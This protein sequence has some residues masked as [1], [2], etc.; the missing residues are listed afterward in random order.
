MK[1]VIWWLGL[2]VL[3][4][5]LPMAL[6]APSSG[7]PNITCE[8]R[9]HYRERLEGIA[10]G[11]KQFSAPATKK[12]SLPA[13]HVTSDH[14][15][16]TRI[17]EGKVAHLPYRFTIKWSETQGKIATLEVNVTGAAGEP[18]AGFPQSSRDPFADAEA[19]TTKAFEIPLTKAM[20][21]QIEER[22][23]AKNQRLTH[24]DLVIVSGG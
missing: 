8:V 17:V 1:N 15:Q 6:A 9:Y 2:L 22:L 11:G 3:G 13:S 16:K 24:V 7:A 18:L 21:R 19:G 5:H 4:A 14:E 23:L 10:P 20:S 12:E